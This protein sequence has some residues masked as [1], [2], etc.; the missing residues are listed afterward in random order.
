[1]W[2]WRESV[3]L[4]SSVMIFG[5]LLGVT[6]I[7]TSAFKGWKAV[8]FCVVLYAVGIIALCGILKMI[9]AIY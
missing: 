3:A 7:G 9:G 8:I 1:M 4:L 2:G 5:W 6:T